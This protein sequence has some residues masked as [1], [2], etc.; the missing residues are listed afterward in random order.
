MKFDHYSLGMSNGV[1]ALAGLTKQALVDRSGSESIDQSSGLV[2]D[3]DLRLPEIHSEIRGPV[4]SITTFVVSVDGTVSS[5]GD[6]VELNEAWM[7]AVVAVTQRL[8]NWADT[9]RVELDGDAYVTASVTGA[10]DVNG[11]AHFDDDQFDPPSGAGVVAIVGDLAGPS[12]ASE[13]VPHGGLRPH[14]A[15]TLT[16]EA[17]AAFANGGFG[18]VDYGPNELVV[19]A[20]FGQLHSGPGPCGGDGDVRHLIVFRSATTPTVTGHQ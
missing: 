17:T 10:A 15:L 14:Q 8:Q 19:M 11:D 1:S 6:N 5:T 4:P 13:P 12:V 18:R 16:D 3:D 2:I 7:P 20:Q 9:S